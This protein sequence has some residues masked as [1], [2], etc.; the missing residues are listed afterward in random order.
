M[1]KLGA[2]VQGFGWIASFAL[3]LAVAGGAAPPAPPAPMAD[4]S[5]LE[6]LERRVDEIARQPRTPELIAAPSAEPAAQREALVPG[7]ATTA[8]LAASIAGLREAVAQIPR[9]VPTH[10]A[11]GSANLNAINALVARVEKGGAIYGSDLLLSTLDEVLARLGRPNSVG[12]DKE[13]LHLFYP[14]GEMTLVVR[15]ESGRV[16]SLG[17]SR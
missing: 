11:V 3:G 1:E 9:P 10:A 14:A 15:L 12:A 16:V 5:R 13:S 4:D 7:G 17:R 2:V 8:E 6:I